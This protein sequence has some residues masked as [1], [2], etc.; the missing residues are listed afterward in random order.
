MTKARSEPPTWRKSSYSGQT[1]QECV[2]VTALDGS[3]DTRD[4]KDPSIGHITV[5]P[6]SWSALLGAIKA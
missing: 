1:A 3:I 4:S 6:E 5:A 2:E